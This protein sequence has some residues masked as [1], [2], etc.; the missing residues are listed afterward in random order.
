[1]SYTPSNQLEI[2]ATGSQQLLGFVLDLGQPDGRAVVTMEVDSRHLNRHGVMHG[3]FITT[4]IDT[5]MG[6][7]AS[8]TASDDGKIPFTTISLTMNFLAPMNPGT[9]TCT[10]R[11]MGGGHKVKFVEG[12]ARDQTGKLVAQATGSFKRVAG[13]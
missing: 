11:I 6:A 3:G 8:L 13:Y 4:A 2:N 12:E 10:G 5:A 9:L 7:T 1:M